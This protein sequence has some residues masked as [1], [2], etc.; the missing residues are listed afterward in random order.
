MSFE[1]DYLF[2]SKLE[3]GCHTGGY[4]PEPEK[5]QSG[6]TIATGFDLGARNENDLRMLGING[7]LLAR[8][9]P[10]LGLKKYTATEF[11]RKNPLVISQAECAQIDQLVK[12][13]YLT[14]LANLYNTAIA[15]NKTRFEDLKPEIQ[16]VITSVSFQHGLGMAKKTPKFWRSIVDQDWKSTVKILRDFQDKYPTRRNKEADYLEKAL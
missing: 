9:K 2:L 4:V 12:A 6:V 7:R 16:T 14:Q 5:S 13:H 8:L 3:G 11:L 10:Y 1:V 15:A